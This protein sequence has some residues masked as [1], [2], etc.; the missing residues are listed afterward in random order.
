MEGLLSTGPA[1]SSFSKNPA[2]ERHRISRP[3]RIV[4]LIFVFFPLPPSKG[5]FSDKKKRPKGGEEGGLK[6]VGQ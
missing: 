2:Y 5:D 1:P 4:A 6:R 3:M